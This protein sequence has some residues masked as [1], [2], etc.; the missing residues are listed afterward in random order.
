MVLVANLDKG[1]F[2]NILTKPITGRSQKSKAQEVFSLSHYDFIPLWA[3]G[4][5]IEG[6]WRTDSQTFS[7]PNGIVKDTPMLPQ[8]VSVFGH[9]IPRLFLSKVLGKKLPVI[10]LWN[11][12]KVLA[13]RFFRYRKARPFRYSP[14][15]VF[16]VL[17]KGEKE[18]GQG[19]FRYARE[20][21]GL[22]LF[23]VLW[24][25][26]EVFAVL[27]LLE[28]VVASSEKVA[29]QGPGV[30]EEFA[31]LEMA[32][33]ENARIRGSAPAVLGNEI[34]DDDFLHLL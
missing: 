2:W 34:G 24:A 5:D 22:V 27:F 12:T 29:S 7:L 20:K 3:N 11:E 33:A 30:V 4:N 1:T 28:G 10:P 21:V 8:D 26:D 15:F 13:L 17:S 25:P 6:V 16:S 18:V 32:I 23:A 14:N 31:K 19:F 9:D